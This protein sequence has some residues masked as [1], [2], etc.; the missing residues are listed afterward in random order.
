M[1]QTTLLALHGLSCMKCVKR[2][3]T[4]LE[5][6]DDVEQV[7]ITLRYARITG[8][9]PTATL[10]ESVTHA[11]YQ[12][13][14][15]S[16]PDIEL[17]LI[18]LSCM[19]CVDSTHQ[20]LAAVPGVFAVEVNRETAKIYGDT[21]PQ[22]LIEAVE[23]AGYQANL[24][25]HSPKKAVPLSEQAPILS[26]VQ[27]VANSSIPAIENSAIE[28][29]DDSILLLLSGMTC[30]SCVNKVQMALQRVPGVKQARVNLA[31]RSA[32]VNGNVLPQALIA[33]VENAGY[34]AE[35]ILDETARR[36][37]Q[38][39]TAQANMKR[40]RWQAILGLMLGVPLMVWGILGGS[41]SIT[42]ETQWP[43]M[44]VGLMTLVVMVLAGGHFYRNAW[45]A[46]KNGSATM[47]SLVALGTGAAWLYSASV[48]LWPGFFP[49]E[50]RH[51][52]YEAS[53]MIIGLI[54]LGHA[55]EQ[56]A[57]QR[58]SQ[59]LERLLDLAPATARSVTEQ[60]EQNIPLSAVQVGMTL[61]LTAG[62]RVPV[63]GEIITGEVW[64]DEAMLTG[65]A[66]AQQKGVGDKVR[67]GTLVDDGTVLFRAEAIGNQTT[68]AR[69]IKLVRQAQSSKPEIGQLADKISAVFVPGVV[70]IA[71]FS[72][73]I[74]Y[75]FGPAPQVVYTLGIA[76]TVLIIACPCALGLATPMSIIS[77]VGR[78]AELG[79]LV[80]DADAL[81]QASNLDT[82]VFDKTGTLTEG[83][84]RVVEIRTFNQVSEQQ[85]LLW[86]AALEQGANHPLARAIV[87]HAA[88]Q[89]LPAVEQF[90]TLRGSGVKGRVAQVELLLGN[91]QLLQQHQI[92]TDEFEQQIQ[93]QATRGVTPVLLAAN[94][95][96]VALIAIRDPLRSD[97]ASAL[98][99]LRQQGYQLVMLTGDNQVTAEAIAREAGIDRVIAGV[100]PEGKA[101]AI[102]QLQAQGSRVAMVGDGINDAPAL[103]QADVGIAMGSGSDIAIETAA[104]TLMRHSLHGVADA[105][106][107]S[108]ATLRNMKQNLL[109]AFIY[110]ALGIPI[111]AGV[112]YP[113]TGTLLS[114]LVAGAAMALSSITVVSN[115]NRLLRFT[116]KA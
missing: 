71:L 100:M 96:L 28:K 50:A 91:A 18:G 25:E 46:L 30:A 39:Q 55:L 76:T 42:P 106:A 109:G 11:G 63:D 62:D 75:L 59:A 48:N 40:F 57:R 61:R 73:A 35:I 102:K 111:A 66:I 3:K 64:I 14:V 7:E 4:A 6:C 22:L 94:G 104:I 26:D 23:R 99:R 45:R 82:L 20:A 78:A 69:I 90:R 5:G 95:Q 15:A 77:G 54:N 34:G 9:A 65:E 84:P 43:W 101:Q 49:D 31:E 29:E 21:A 85:A 105:L 51:L 80:R 70:L 74:W 56:Q 83:C 32:L 36:E 92:M 44:L 52:Y 17:Q 67:A 37:R 87:E 88:G 108:K 33:A 38:Q 12:A 110:N 112:L 8:A 41:M 19:H 27:A 13:E 89:E 16:Q 72:A 24:V 116:P 114:P 2:V 93:Q 68:L 107:L 47:D 98:Q 58:S 79:I 81:Q 97:S 60:G 86:A 115:A 1:S 113:L 103:A 10:I 53:A